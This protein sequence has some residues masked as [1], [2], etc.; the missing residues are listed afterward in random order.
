MQ[1]IVALLI[2]YLFIFT[3]IGLASALL[4]FGRISPFV[5]RKVIHIGVSNWWL[6]ALFWMPSLHIALIGPV[7]FII[8]NYISYRK[9]IFS[10]M[11]HEIPRKNLGTIYFPVSL[12]IMV[13]LSFA[14]PMPKSAA[15]A[16]ILI[17]GYGDGIAAL[18][19]YGF[20][21]AGKP[22]PFL[23]QRKTVQGTLSMFLVSLI[24][25]ALVLFLSGDGAL[26]SASL[27]VIPALLFI[28]ATAA[29]TEA[30]TPFGLDNLTIPLVSGLLYW[31]L[32]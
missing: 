14:G 6:I 3:T 31:W 11:E 23:R 28:G 29:L 27:Y 30:I 32:F 15:T 2:S 7:S 18:I 8:I 25:T 17:L 10:A 4:S 16:A 5:T 12:V 22:I 26:S 20:R 1:E 24:V 13:L 19:G 9:H 21:E